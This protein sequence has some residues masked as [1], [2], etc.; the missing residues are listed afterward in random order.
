MTIKT[1]YQKVFENFGAI[2]N[3]P[4]SALRHLEA[5][6]RISIAMFGYIRNFKNKQTGSKCALGS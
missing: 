2:K 5:I 3:S 1:S 6:E 4:N